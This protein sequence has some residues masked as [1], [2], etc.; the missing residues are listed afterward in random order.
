MFAVALTATIE[1]FVEAICHWTPIIV[2]TSKGQPISRPSYVA[3]LEA[4]EKT[5]GF[6]RH[7]LAAYE[8]TQRLREL[9]NCYKHQ[10]GRASSESAAR[11]GIHDGH[12]IPFE[13]Q[14]WANMLVDPWSFL[15]DLS[16]RLIGHQ[17]RGGNP[18]AT[19]S[20]G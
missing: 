16:Q 7:Q 6:D 5:F 11:L 15:S 2:N 18:P 17:M 14:D 10:R 12:P 3:R 9:S 8:T 1:K 19:T 4:I 13:K 20:W